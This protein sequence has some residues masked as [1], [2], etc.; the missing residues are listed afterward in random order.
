MGIKGTKKF[1]FED[2]QEGLGFDDMMSKVDDEVASNDA[3]EEI[4]ENAPVLVK[5][6][7]NID[8]AT[9]T[10][11]KAILSLEDATQ[12]CKKAELKLFTAVGTISGKVDTINTHIDKVLE[13][14]PTKL[15]VEVH[16]SDADMKA[17]Q[18]LFDE[19]AKEINKHITA[20][21]QNLNNMLIEERKRTREM[22][23][24]YDGVWF[25]HYGQWFFMFFF[26]IGL[27]VVG[28][29]IVVPLIQHIGWLK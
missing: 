7:D 6:N 9:D 13:Q 4:L 28:V 21:Y 8:K 16:A 2:T 26:I 24:D 10:L 11:C 1:E 5:L 29:T 25:G 14:A 22:F 3:A 19:K 12:E 17:I 23:N 18:D 27:I 20:E 15:T